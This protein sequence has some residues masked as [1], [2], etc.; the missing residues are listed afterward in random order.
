[1]A[2]LGLSFLDIWRIRKE[3]RRRYYASWILSYCA[4]FEAS[5]ASFM[6]G[7]MFLNRAHFD[8]TYHFVAIVIAFGV[9]ARREMAAEMNKPAQSSRGY[10]GMLVPVESPGFRRRARRTGG[11]RST[12]LGA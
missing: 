1:M 2:M 12:P 11:F 3:A 4:M 8:L 6:C 5:L 10:R 9:I 7:S